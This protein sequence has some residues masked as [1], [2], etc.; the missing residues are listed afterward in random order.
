MSDSLPEVILY[1]DG[2]CN[3]NPVAG[4]K[5]SGWLGCPVE[6][7]EFKLKIVGNYA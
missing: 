4:G 6:M 7:K 1:T 2:E 3:G 5:G